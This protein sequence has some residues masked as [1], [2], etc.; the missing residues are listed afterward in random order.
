[1]SS[2]SYFDYKFNLDNLKEVINI[3]WE[4]DKKFTIKDNFGHCVVVSY[5]METDSIAKENLMWNESIWGISSR[6]LLIP[7]SFI[8]KF[9][10][11]MNERKW[12]I[13][14]EYQ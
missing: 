4:G 14:K 7:V 11:D 5:P 1:M 12:W 8:E 3:E 6:K 2:K 10:L 9:G 13:K